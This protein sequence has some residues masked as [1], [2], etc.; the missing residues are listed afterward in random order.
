MILTKW[1][2]IGIILSGEGR[3][4]MT[5]CDIWEIGYLGDRIDCFSCLHISLVYN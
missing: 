3:Q 1:I 5:G 2:G 4:A